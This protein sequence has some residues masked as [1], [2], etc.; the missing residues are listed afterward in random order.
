M[1]LT[2]KQ[3]KTVV[4]DYLKYLRT[5]DKITLL[6]KDALIELHETKYL[7]YTLFNDQNK[8]IEL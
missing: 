6:S 8:P 1:E 3:I 7:Y 5:E 4:E 2:K